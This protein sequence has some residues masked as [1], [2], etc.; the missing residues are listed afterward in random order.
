MGTLQAVMSCISGAMAP[1]LSPEKRTQQVPLTPF[2]T[3][4]V[5][6]TLELLGRF[7]QTANSS[8]TCFVTHVNMIP[9]CHCDERLL[10]DLSTSILQQKEGMSEV[11]EDS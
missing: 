7:L 11:N 8:L 6:G 1:V 4:A 9:S 10:L 5:P 2:C 3:T